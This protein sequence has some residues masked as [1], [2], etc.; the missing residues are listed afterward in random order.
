MLRNNIPP[1]VLAWLALAFGLAC[2]LLAGE[3]HGRQS[4][5]ADGEC[6]EQR[7]WMD[8]GEKTKRGLK[9]DDGSRMLF[10][11]KRGYWVLYAG[12]MD[13]APKAKEE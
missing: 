10:V 12:E 6:A 7:R 13:W 9:G 8:H 3:Y 4:G 5:I 11:G 1:G 2:G